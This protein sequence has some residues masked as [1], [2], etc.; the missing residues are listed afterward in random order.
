MGKRW[1]HLKTV[2]TH[3][4]YV[5]KAC[6]KLGIPFR[7]IMHDLS[8]FNPIEFNE[9]VKYWTGNRSPIDNC[10]DETGVSQAW[11]HHRGRN[12]H[13][14]EYWVDDF[15]KGMDPK[16]MPFK[17][18]LEMLAD[19]IGAGKAYMKDKFSYEAEWQWWLNK[20]K[21]VIMHPVIYQFIE[22]SLDYL[23]KFGESALNKKNA[24][25][26]YFYYKE[27]WERT[28]KENQK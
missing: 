4:K 24:K 17:Y 18:T 7:G 9:S 15:S 21:Q 19:Y 1:N 25:Q 13:H 20:R 6:V 3:K 11:L 23:A 8:K 26:F 22:F 2:C 16:L 28:Q 5:F 10:K 14:W 27:L 12:P